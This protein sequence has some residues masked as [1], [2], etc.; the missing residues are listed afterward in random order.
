MFINVMLC[1]P[2]QSPSIVGDKGRY[3]AARAAVKLEKDHLVQSNQ[4]SKKKET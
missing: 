2:E 3:R 4:N 1:N